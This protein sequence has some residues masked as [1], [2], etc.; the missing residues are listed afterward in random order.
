VSGILV[1]RMCI[2]ST[3]MTHRACNLQSS[4]DA[5]CQMKMLVGSCRWSVFGQP[6]F[7]NYPRNPTSIWDVSRNSIRDRQPR[8]SDARCEHIC[9]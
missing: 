8:I 7:R 1:W 3:S 6:Q 4:V 5:R 2:A 9:L